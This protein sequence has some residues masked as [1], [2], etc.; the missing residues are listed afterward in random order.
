MK[1]MNPIAQQLKSSRR[2]PRRRAFTLIELLVVITVIAILAGLVIVGTNRIG[3][4]RKISTATAELKEIAHAIENYHSTFGTYPPGNINDTD[5]AAV[6]NQLYYELTGVTPTAGN[7]V[8][9][10]VDNDTIAATAYLSTFGVQSV[11]NTTHTNGEDAKPAHNF[12]AG[13]KP[14]RIGEIT[15]GTDQ[16]DVLITSVGGPDDGYAP[17]GARGVNPFRYKAPNATNNNS[18][19]YDLWINLSMGATTPAG[20]I[21]NPQNMRL[22]CNWNNTVQK[23][24]QLP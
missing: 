17:M 19:S 12:L 2:Q 3:Q 18:G 11:L 20:V 24:S 22:I 15:N 4:F 9:Q 1:Y 14:S 6:T 7:T 5:T 8:F 23:N 21:N 16:V 10:A 13:L